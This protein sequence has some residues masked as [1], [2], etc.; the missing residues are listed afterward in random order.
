V[1][2][3][4]FGKFGPRKKEKWEIWFLASAAR[5]LPGN[6]GIRLT[7]YNKAFIVFLSGISE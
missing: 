1:R 5:P 6:S 7:T 3:F 2:Y 4:L